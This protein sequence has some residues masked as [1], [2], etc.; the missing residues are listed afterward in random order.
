M[1][2]SHLKPGAWFELA[3]VGTVVTSDDNSVPADWPPKRCND[4]VAEGIK[5]LG[6]IIPDSDYLKK[7]LVESGFVDIT[8]RLH[9]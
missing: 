9:P 3:E 7:L 6:G 5:A 1:K 2:T 8:V 4:L